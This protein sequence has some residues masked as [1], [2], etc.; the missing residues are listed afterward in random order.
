MKSATNRGAP[1]IEEPQVKTCLVVGAA[2]EHDRAAD[3]ATRGGVGDLGLHLRL[4]VPGTVEG[5]HVGETNCRAVAAELEQ[6]GPQAE[7]IGLADPDQVHGVRLLAEPEAGER[8][9]LERLARQL[10]REE[11]SRSGSCAA[12]GEG[13]LDAGT[14]R[15]ARMIVARGGEEQQHDGRD[16][17]M[18]DLHIDLLDL[19]NGSAAPEPGS[20]AS[21]SKSR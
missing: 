12:C 2:L 4:V 11:R 19:K 14:G 16:R 17:T 1:E 21:P 15:S 10:N 18:T 13:R 3:P 7:R 20:C 6:R 5:E 8:P 9:E